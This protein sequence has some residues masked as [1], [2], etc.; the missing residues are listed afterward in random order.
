MTITRG[1]ATNSATSALEPFS[2]ERRDPQPGDVVIEIAY[3]GICHSDIHTARSE[4]GP[5]FYPCVP[6]H[7]IVGK[8]TGVGKKV[9][10]FKVG[11]LPEWA[12]WW[13]HAKNVRP[14]RIM[15]SSF[16][17]KQLFSLTTA[18]SLANKRILLAGIHSKSL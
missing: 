8:V 15:K 11:I 10:K 4:W 12:V 5:S 6:G 13:A 14:A 3:C 18:W 7:E 1:Y 9:T 16:A 2:F 17:K